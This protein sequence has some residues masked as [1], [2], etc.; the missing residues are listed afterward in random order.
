MGIDEVGIDKVGIDEVGR[1]HCLRCP[2]ITGSARLKKIMN[3][4]QKFFF[5]FFYKCCLLK[6]F[7]SGENSC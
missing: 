7:P 4:Q 5:F 2:K 6:C 1:Y 3:S